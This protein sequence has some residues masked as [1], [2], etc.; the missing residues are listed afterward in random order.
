MSKS[1]Q[2]RENTQIKSMGEVLDDITPNL[3][4]VGKSPVQ[5]KSLKD[6]VWEYPLAVASAFKKLI[7]FS[8]ILVFSFVAVCLCL[9]L[10]S[11]SFAE[12][13]SKSGKENSFTE[14]SVGY[15]SSFNPLFISTNYVDRTVESLVF[16]KFINID[17][18]GNPVEGIAKSWKSSDDS[19]TYDFV[20][21]RDRKWSDGS[22]LTIDDVVFTF[23]TAKDLAATGANTFGSSLDGA[24]VEKIDDDTIRFTLEEVNPVFFELISVYIIPKTQLENVDLAAIE[25]NRFSLYPVGSGKYVVTA[26]EGNAVYLTDNPYDFYTPN[27]KNVTLKL[28]TDINSLEMAY[29]IGSLDAIGGWDKTEFSFLDEYP[30]VVEYSITDS[31]RSKLIFFNIRKESLA[32]VN[33]RQALN[34]LLDKE[35]MLKEFGAGTHI[36][37]GPIPESSWAYKSD[38]EYYTYNAE[39]AASLLADAGYTKNESNGY[40]EDENGALLSFSISY[41]K[42][43]T[44]NR[45]VSLLENYYK[46]EGVV[47]KSQ[48]Y[49]YDQ[50][51]Q[52]VI[53]TRDFELLLYEVEL[54]IDPDS[55]SLWHS[56]NVDYPKL[57]LSGYDY[58]RVD[59]LLEEARKTVDKDTR[60]QRYNTFQRYLMAD[61]PAVFLYNPDFT[62]YVNPN[63]KGISLDGVYSSINR[64]NNIE[65]WY[66]DKE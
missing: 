18:Q 3:K 59:R 27:I 65:E 52:E 64:F 17:A 41:L 1:K 20:I 60:V 38:L 30:N 66:W 61:S 33:I 26:T 63:L 56:L 45:F 9:L 40:Y 48:G 32:S 5:R 16:E 29:R 58:D 49:N 21:N 10:Q 15:I 19:L 6:I 54:T 51:T 4:V 47:L 37:N 44:N 43:D 39:K 8:Y 12:V 2:V 28:Y 31:Q 24:T 42:N 35:N 7:P 55:Y 62:Y 13:F 57:N 23:Q 25:N 22:D 36:V 50:I 53:A 14:G 34:Y 11:S 46:K